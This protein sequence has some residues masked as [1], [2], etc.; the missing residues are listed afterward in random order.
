MRK[1]LPFSSFYAVL[2][3]EFITTESKIGA[4]IYK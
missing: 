1:S 3:I 4:K 2:N